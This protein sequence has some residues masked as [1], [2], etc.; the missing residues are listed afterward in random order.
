M[1]TIIQ[2]DMAP[3]AIGP[4]SQAVKANGLLFISGQIPLDLVTGQLVYGGVGMQ[5]RQ[6]FTISKPFSGDHWPMPSKQ[7]FIYRIWIASQK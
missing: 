2:T 1:K 4:Y 3:Q 6:V 5:T 7:Q